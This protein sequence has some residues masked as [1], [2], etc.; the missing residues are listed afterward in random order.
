MIN[1]IK[2]LKFWLKKT[3][4]THDKVSNKFF[5][6]GLP[7]VTMLFEATH[8]SRRAKFTLAQRTAK[9]NVDKAFK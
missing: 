9:N 5:A 7:K 1:K 3:T 4:A 8:T 6:D 2:A